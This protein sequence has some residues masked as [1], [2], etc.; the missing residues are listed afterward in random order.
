MRLPQ[1]IALTKSLGR[2]VRD[3]PE[4]FAW[5]DSGGD[6]VSIEFANGR[7]V[8]WELRRSAQGQA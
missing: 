2:K 8:R 7:C 6:E 1:I 5:R 4:T 3:D